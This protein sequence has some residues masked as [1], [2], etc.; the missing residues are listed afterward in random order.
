MNA[1]ALAAATVALMG[2]GILV[3]SHYTATLNADQSSRMVTGPLPR[4]MDGDGR[5]ISLGHDLF[6]DRRLSGS[7]RLNCASCHDLARNG[8]SPTSL[9]QGD[10]GQPL[11]FNTPTIFN[12]LYNFRL[13]WEGRTR[14]L[15][16]MA[17]WT[18]NTPHLMNS[19]GLWTQRLADDRRLVARFRDS[20]GSGPSEA[21]IS[22]ALGRFME[23]L[24]TPNAPFDRWLLD[25][26]AALTPQQVRGYAR[27]K[28]LGCASCHQGVNIGGNM[29]QRR[30]IFHPLGSPSPR[31]LR[32]PSLRNVSVT[33]PYF[34]DG[35]VQSLPMAIQQ[36]ARAQLDLTIGARDLRD[37]SAFLDSLT[38]T[39]KGRRLRPAA[40]SSIRR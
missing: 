14:N 7:M 33:A 23:T 9:D 40:A 29:F 38:G 25:D 4:P 19:K 13:G 26:K 22:D 27:F 3:S 2:T 6:F 30:G 18:L 11:R 12:S 21:A 10:L 8:S 16:N 35:S 28:A 32:V 39:Y 15:R 31:Y 1:F 17:F 5:K 36:M 20:Y 37:I 24:V 34:H